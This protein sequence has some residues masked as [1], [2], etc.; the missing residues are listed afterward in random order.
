ME[1]L[2]E[3]R[4]RGAVAVRLEDFIQSM[5]LDGQASSSTANWENWFFME[6]QQAGLAGRLLHSL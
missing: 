3:V 6:N 4:R 1:K 5:L 2:S